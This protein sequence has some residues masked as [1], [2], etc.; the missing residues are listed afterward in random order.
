MRL[1]VVLI[2]FI[3]SVCVS[4]SFFPKKELNGSAQERPKLAQDVLTNLSPV[5]STLEIL[6]NSV[7][8]GLAP[9]A[10]AALDFFVVESAIVKKDLR[11]QA[12]LIK[13]GLEILVDLK[14]AKL[15]AEILREAIGA[16]R[17]TIILFDTPVLQ[18]IQKLGRTNTATPLLLRSD[19]FA[20]SNPMA[21]GL[22]VFGALTERAGFLPTDGGKPAIDAATVEQFTTLAQNILTIEAKN[23]IV[24]QAYLL[25]AFN[26][27]QALD[28]SRNAN[29]EQT[30]FTISAARSAVTLAIALQKQKALGGNVTQEIFASAFQS[31]SSAT[32]QAS[33]AV[34]V[35]QPSPGLVVIPE[36]APKL[37]PLTGSLPEGYSDW[38]FFAVEPPQ[39]GSLDVTKNPPVYVPNSSF[40]NS[41]SYR[42]RACQPIVTSLCS[43]EKIIT[44]TRPL[45]PWAVVVKPANNNSDFFSRGVEL[46]CMPVMRS[47]DH[48]P[49][50]TWWKQALGDTQLTDITSQSVQ[51]GRITLN[52]ISIGDR[53][54]CK[55]FA[56]SELGLRSVSST[57]AD[58]PLVAMNSP[59]QDITAALPAG[60]LV[61]PL[62]ETVLD[63][64]ADKPS[65]SSKREI[66]R[67]SVADLDPEDPLA[68]LTV[69]GCDG[70][71]P[72]PFVV[73][74]LVSAASQRTAVLY[75]QS[76]LNFEEKPFYELT[77]RAVDGGRPDLN[78]PGGAEFLKTIRFDVIN[79]NDPITAISPV[80]VEVDENQ[81]LQITQLSVADQDC[82]ANSSCQNTNYSYSFETVAEQA[83]QDS[84]HFEIVGRN[85]LFKGPQPPNFESAHPEPY[86]LKIKATD[87][88]AAADDDAQVKTFTSQLKVIIK[89]VNEVPQSLVLV[90]NEISENVIAEIGTL[91]V[92]DVDFGQT[93]DPSKF[94]FS[95]IELTQ[96]PALGDAFEIVG[97]SLRTKKKLNFE[98]IKDSLESEVVA[99]QTRYYFNVRIT[100][101]DK[102]PQALSVSQTF[103]IYLN[104]VNE[105]PTGF[106]ASRTILQEQLAADDLFSKIDLIGTDPDLTAQTFSFVIK[107]VRIKDQSNNAVR[108]IAGAGENPFIIAGSTLML[109]RPLNYANNDR[110]FELDIEVS[111]GEFAATSTLTILVSRLQL[112]AQSFAEDPATS[113]P[114]SITTLRKIADICVSVEESQFCND[115]EFFIQQG[116]GAGATLVTETAKLR[117]VGQ[118]LNRISSFNHEQEPTI[119]VVLVAR[120]KT[121]I[122]EK[123]VRTFTL[124]VSNVDDPVLGMVFRDADANIVNAN[125]T[126]F[127][128]EKTTAGSLVG[129]VEVLDEDTDAS[130]FWAAIN[131]PFSATYFTLVPKTDLRFAELRVGSGG[132]PEKKDV[133]GGKLTVLA[134][135]TYSGGVQQRTL[136]FQLISHAVLAEKV[137]KSAG[138][139]Y[140]KQTNTTPLEIAFT[141]AD[142]T[143]GAVCS[144][145][146]GPNSAGISVTPTDPDSVISSIQSASAGGA[147]ASLKDCI[148]TVTPRSNRSGEATLLVAVRS[149]TALGVQEAPTKLSLKV[150]FWRP[151]ELN[152][153]SRI[154]L[155]AGEALSGVPCAVSFSDQSGG[156]VSADV[157]LGVSACGLNL[158]TASDTL[159]LASF[160]SSGCSTGVSVSVNN[161]YGTSFNLSHQLRL[162]PRLFG[163]NGA[164]N[165]VARDS[166]GNVYLG[167]SFT[168]VNPVSAPALTSV[169][170]ETSA[171]LDANG[172]PIVDGDANPVLDFQGQRSSACNLTEG[173]NGPVRAIIDA[174][175]GDFWVGGEFTH[176]RS[177]EVNRL[178]RL[179]CSGERVSWLPAGK[180][181]NGNVLA[182]AKALDGSLYVGGSFTEYN[183]VAAHGVVR[184]NAD[185]VRE[186]KANNP[187]EAVFHSQLPA[188]AAVNAIALTPVSGSAATVQTIW[189]GGKFDS[190]DESATHKNLVR[191]KADGEI[192][193]GYVG[194]ALDGDVL[195]LSVVTGGATVGSDTVI[196]G[197][198]VGGLFNNYRGSIAKRLVKISDDGTPD[199]AFNSPTDGF[200]ARVDTLV[201]DGVNL[202]A[203]GGFTRYR[204]TTVNRL[205]K[206]SLIDGSLQTIGFNHPSADGAVKALILTDSNSK[207][208]LGGQFTHVGAQVHPRLAMINTDTGAPYANFNKGLGFNGS[209]GALSLFDSGKQ[210]LVGGEFSAFEGAASARLAKFDSNG[211]FQK[212]FTSALGS[213]GVS[214]GDVET[215]LLVMGDLYV[216]GGFTHVGALSRSGLAKIDASTGAPV[217]SPSFD[218]GSGFN[219]SVKV[220][221]KS[222][223]DDSIYVGGLF[224]S[225]NGGSSPRL[226]RLSN[227]GALD[228]D[229]I[230]D[231]GFTSPSGGVPSVS[232]LAFTPPA[233]GEYAIFAAGEFDEYKGEPARRLVKLDTSGELFGGF[234]VAAGANQAIHAL[235]L[236]GNDLFVGGQFTSYAGSTD[237]RGLA[238][239]NATTGQL[240]ANNQ[241]NVNG[242]VRAL[243]V[244]SS[245]GAL[246]VGG[247]F[248]QLNGADTGALFKIDN[249]NERNMPFTASVVRHVNPQFVSGI[250]A[251]LFAEG[252]DDASDVLFAGG[253]F[254]SYRNESASSHLRVRAQ[255]G[256]DVTAP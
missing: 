106:S 175:G 92:D 29:G 201:N 152:C 147:S 85:V 211:V 50:Y 27:Q 9:D 78:F 145:S 64:E 247:T 180:G 39:N 235:A 67:L 234:S 157:S 91:T 151:P 225:Y 187:S 156:G 117:I 76:P 121:D 140:D 108:P 43:D 46:V 230:V 183:E 194:G 212:N 21:L 63:S 190:Y 18:Y 182:L 202:F 101:T 220:I 168:G 23:F 161:K 86:I 236:R 5:N 216:G 143:N 158:D 109:S 71:T 25:Q 252:A 88:T 165:A 141:I 196:G 163:T 184:L 4:C 41:D 167:G 129:T 226:V 82:A 227:T 116:V 36:Q 239:V 7:S 195:A 12:D 133:A 188:G 118:T 142:E 172:A 97:N 213:G 51:A 126:S 73:E 8:R 2:A 48:V 38:K 146:T 110:Y 96:V 185:G 241:F 124:T 228:V 193:G 186:M 35:G 130:F 42:F 224:E 217:S 53:V 84:I 232:A 6:Y 103:K 17:R 135:A 22:F 62:Q 173:F 104:D 26:P 164:V 31:W 95:K 231:A 57:T 20:T 40:G 198:V 105:A 3:A 233:D 68:G 44:V 205:A 171:L 137:P 111:D 219:K 162:A 28:P 131:T 251:L 13:S 132:L 223:V 155:A 49:I 189:L 47:E 246:F 34:A 66:A 178:V 154:S 238:R 61:F 160:P 206:I 139:F 181:F 177:T 87:T 149:N 65:D 83:V 24:I 250:Y 55:V 54:L 94:E 134:S 79:R 74:D 32:K 58:T 15:D 37:D 159:S 112:S 237:T 119:Q 148:L 114:V 75:L 107:N 98:E 125:Q 60:K 69:S 11:P 191:V 242:S 244:D 249:Q 113:P 19:L 197:V 170:L 70:K 214:G 255:T 208:L 56:E 93:S 81:S 1:H 10:Q 150:A 209:A 221:A 243:S 169:S 176:Y 166:S 256:T 102:T 52:N 72:C 99:S 45:P 218:V 253:L 248:T 77:L 16:L 240:A 59:P 215:L 115:W 128:L 174:G 90:G 204:N 254:S 123:M 179:R 89:D 120:K 127:A 144:L 80:E 203:G 30:Q 200:N 136:E 207:L 199:A 122:N 210:L 138:A 153:P 245:A 222:P 33:D 100:A 229:F 14:S 192:A